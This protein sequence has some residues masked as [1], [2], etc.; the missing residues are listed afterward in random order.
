MNE[1]SLDYTLDYT[2]LY[3]QNTRA[4]KLTLFCVPDML[5]CIAS[6]CVCCRRWYFQWV[7]EVKRHPQGGG[8]PQ[9][10][11]KGSVN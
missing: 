2:V 11:S 8:G 7:R 3:N 9:S 1:E 6:E 4:R 10:R 5:S